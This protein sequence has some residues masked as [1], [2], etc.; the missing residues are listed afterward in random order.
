MTTDDPV[1]K[2]LTDAN[3][4]ALTTTNT[5]EAERVL[6][7]VLVAVVQ[8]LG[9]DEIRLGLSGP[10]LTNGQLLVIAQRSTATGS[11]VFYDWEADALL[12]NGSTVAS[13]TAVPR[14]RALQI[15]Q[16][17]ETRPPG[18]TVGSMTLYHAVTVASRQPAATGGSRLGPVSDPSLPSLLPPGVQPS[19]GTWVKVPQGTVVLSGT[20][21]QSGVT[22]S[23][24]FALRDD[25]ALTN[26]DIAHARLGKLAGADAVELR[27][28]KQGAVAFQNLT[29]EIAHRGQQVSVP[30]KHLFQHFAVGLDN[31]LMTVPQIDFEKYPDGVVANPAV[32]SP[33]IVSG[34]PRQAKQLAA[35]LRAGA[36]PLARFRGRAG[37][38]WTAEISR[39]GTNAD[40]RKL[41]FS[42]VTVRALEMCSSPTAGR[43]GILEKSACGSSRG[44]AACGPEG[45]R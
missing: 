19:D 27:L 33:D 22:S 45:R 3:P 26:A 9:A 10:H 42:Q 11:L 38:S 34:S 35:I 21:N 37:A 1:L 39:R 28:T 30:T 16:G 29:S 13:Q 20:L 6:R 36:L 4:V 5:A 43:C 14:S 24:F 18:G 17:D 40:A 15:S 12:P 44:G 32:R 25:V 41:P 2:E 8:P 7:R 23:R 31:S